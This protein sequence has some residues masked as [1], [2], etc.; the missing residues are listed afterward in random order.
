M[1]KA[2]HFYLDDSGT[3]T[4]NRRPLAF[5]PKK[6]EHFALGGILINAEDEGPARAAYDTFC[7][8]WGIT[9]PLHSVEIRHSTK[10]FSWLRRDATEYSRF[11]LDL[12][13]FLTSLP[14]TGIA[15]TID[16]PGYDS[17]YRHLGKAQWK[18]CKT[19][20]PIVVERAAKFARRDGR[21]LRVYPERSIKA[22]EE[23]LHAYF[24]N[25]RVNG[26]PFTGGAAAAYAPLSALEC[27]DTLYELKFKR[28]S[29]PMIQVADLYLWPI[30]LARY[31]P[32]NRA[33]LELQRRGRLIE[34]AL[35]KAEWESCGS[36]YSCFEL[37]D[38]HNRGR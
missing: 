33:Y 19:A 32:R 18:L 6:R 1:P 10:N 20:F 38:A 15:C 11:M 34:C 26:A 17:R 30:A 7:A 28:K 31:E 25:L 5:D 24:D 27:A 9:Y 13:G 3:R 2:L 16:R 36:K 35:P 29:S 23:L 4:L 12:T 37:V 21:K 8:R 22:D 14:V